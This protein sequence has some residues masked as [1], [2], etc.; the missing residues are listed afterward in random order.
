M[1]GK[2]HTYIQTTGSRIFISRQYESGNWYAYADNSQIYRIGK[3]GTERYLSYY[4]YDMTKI[5]CIETSDYLVEKTYRADVLHRT[6]YKAG[7]KT[8]NIRVYGYYIH[9]SYDYPTNILDYIVLDDHIFVRHIVNGE[10]IYHY[11]ILKDDPSVMCVLP[12]ETFND[13][14]IMIGRIDG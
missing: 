8:L 3:T 10:N 11:T 7:N 14:L 13:A 2:P 1:N 12:P 4:K 5:I 9:I 6:V